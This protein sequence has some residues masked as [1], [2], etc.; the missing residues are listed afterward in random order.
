MILSCP[1]RGRPELDRKLPINTWGTEATYNTLA[2]L[3]REEDIATADLWEA[4]TNRILR[5]D[6]DLI[7]EARAV[8]R[9]NRKRGNINGR[10]PT[11]HQE[12]PT[13]ELPILPQGA[14][15]GL[16]VPSHRRLPHDAQPEQGPSAHDRRQLL[17]QE[18]VLRADSGESPRV[19]NLWQAL[20][21]ALK[22]RVSEQN[23]EVWLS[24]IR[25]VTTHEK[26]IV[27]GCPNT[28]FKE[29]LTEHYTEVIKEELIKTGDP[30]QPIF[31]VM[32]LPT[33]E[34]TPAPIAKPEPPK[35]PIIAELEAEAAEQR[36]LDP[37]GMNQAVIARLS[38]ILSKIQA[39]RREIASAPRP[40]AWG[41]EGGYT[42]GDVSEARRAL[43][44][45]K[46]NK[47]TS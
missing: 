14:H 11:T 13:H 37:R 32:E 38:V 22:A 35:D 30:R 16:A 31:Q 40:S 24:S 42:R 6:N 29:Y 41:T 19:V 20:A 34:P 9:A 43:A 26:V 18:Q 2:Q 12:D 4:V 45:R 17:E 23:F 44:K 7:E 21:P 36:A 10:Q 27:L 46:P 1:D 25:L 39:R 8:K 28:F 5:G 3:R 15:P 33:P 47:D